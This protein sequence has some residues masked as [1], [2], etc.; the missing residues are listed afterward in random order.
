MASFSLIHTLIEE[1]TKN[2]GNIVIFESDSDLAAYLYKEFYS[3]YFSGKDIGI[4][5]QN[6]LDQIT[7]YME[8][9][10]IEDMMGYRIF[11]VP[12]S[13]NINQK[14]YN[15]GEYLLKKSM[16]SRFSDLFTRLEFESIWVKN[17]LMQIP[18]FAKALPVKTLFRKKK[19][20]ESIALLVSTGPSL[21]E[22]LPLI[23]KYR[24]K[25]FIACVDSAYRI[26]SDYGITPHLIITLDAQ[27]F[28]QRHIKNLPC[29]I[30]GKEP[31]LYADLAANPQVTRC[32]R[33]P[34][35]YGVTAQYGQNTRMVT[36]GSDY[37]EEELLRGPNT[38]GDIQSGGSVSTSLFDLLRQMNFEKIILAGSDFAYSNREIHSIG[39]HHVYQWMS[40]NL[41]RTNTLE[42]IN[43]SILQKREYIM[44]KGVSG[45]KVPGDYV[46]GLYAHWFEEAALKVKES[47]KIYNASF[48]GLILQ[49]MKNLSY[50]AFENVLMKTSFNSAQ[51]V[52]DIIEFINN[53]GSS[54]SNNNEI[55]KFITDLTKQLSHF[56]DDSQNNPEVAPSFLK[57]AGRKH[58]IL[59]KR[60]D[61]PEMLQNQKKE[62]TAFARKLLNIFSKITN[63]N[64]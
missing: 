57:Y 36:P 63:E 26:L 22:A 15:N 3:D 56:L 28:T 33:G 18:A 32:W 24:D 7:D 44:Q 64:D 27:S 43:N 40:K 30:P 31:F 14:F 34:L 12:G 2:G 23:K 8:H 48:N 19:H 58:E 5:T 1:M 59:A 35:L 25:I 52:N 60:K 49:N 10:S 50:D 41:N 20:P 62:Q 54:I 45:K 11:K 9:L 16:A 37:I 13:M 39:T 4:I 29:G 17:A 53:H 38:L 47:T 61:Q 51:Y 42:S 21:R 55:N 6:N 46:L